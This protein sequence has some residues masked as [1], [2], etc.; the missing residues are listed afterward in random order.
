MGCRVVVEGLSK[1]AGITV[2]GKLVCCCGYGATG[3]GVA[4]G[5]TSS[6]ARVLVSEVDPICALQAVMAGLQVR[7]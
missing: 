5:L 1:G 3:K 4:A 7:I 2:A 6:G